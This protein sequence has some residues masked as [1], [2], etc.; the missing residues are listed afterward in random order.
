VTKSKKKNCIAC[1]KDFGSTKSCTHDYAMLVNEKVYQRVPADKKC[2]IC[3]VA[4]DAYHHLDCENE[5]CPICGNKLIDEA[6]CK[7]RWIDV[8]M[9]GQVSKEVVK[10][11]YPIVAWKFVVLTIITFGLFPFY[12]MYRTWRFVIKMQKME[13]SPLVVTILW[14]LF[15]FSLTYNLKKISK[16][17]YSYGL[18]SVIIPIV[19][20]V[21]MFS[22]LLDEDFIIFLPLSFI[23]LL[24]LQ[25]GMQKTYFYLMPERLENRKKYDKSN[26]KSYIAIFVLAIS[27]AGVSYYDRVYIPN[28]SPEKYIKE[29]SVLYKKVK[30]INERYEECIDVINNYKDEIGESG[31]VPVTGTEWANFFIKAKE[32][33]DKIKDTNIRCKS[34][35][36]EYE[37]ENDKLIDYVY[38]NVQY[39]KDPKYEDITLP[40]L[41][42]WRE[43]N[44]LLIR[45]ADI[46]DQ[47]F[48]LQKDLLD[49]MER[50]D[51]IDFVETQEKLTSLYNQ[52]EDIEIQRGEVFRTKITPNEAGVK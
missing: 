31:T 13:I 44:S 22:G 15:I 47:I 50:K 3:G 52:K 24:N 12:W 18:S 2:N 17:N 5:I 10:L 30:I 29:A 32:N 9:S 45:K 43:N 40:Y 42:G 37:K 11:A 41:K 46:N 48:I 35:L 36:L 20:I 39:F 51:V 28:H 6:T 19:Y 27:I 25:Q 33:M 4:K 7:C 1:E 34:I 26:Y 49:A 8:S 14:P 38:Q 23:P 21:M 16:E